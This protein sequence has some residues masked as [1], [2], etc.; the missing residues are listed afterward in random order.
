MAV[1]YEQQHG[2][3]DVKVMLM[4]EFDLGVWGIWRVDEGEAG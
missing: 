4:L 1:S 3:A 2:N